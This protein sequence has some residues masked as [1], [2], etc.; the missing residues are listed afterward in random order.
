YDSQRRAVAPGDACERG[1]EL[2][3]GGDYVHAATNGRTAPGNRRRRK[4]DGESF[5]ILR[6][7]RHL[8]VLRGTRPGEA[9]RIQLRNRCLQRQPASL[10]SGFSSLNGPSLP[11]AAPT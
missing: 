7:N 5:R 4:V 11:A 9:G 1:D 10:L 2:A 8:R 6:R 3:A